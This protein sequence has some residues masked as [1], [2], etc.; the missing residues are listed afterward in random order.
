M[1]LLPLP[2]SVIARDG[3]AAGMTIRRKKGAKYNSFMAA[4][5]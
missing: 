1:G 2:L 4:R 3:W 5:P